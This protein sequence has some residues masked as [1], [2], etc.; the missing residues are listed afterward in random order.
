MT[1]L[2]RKISANQVKCKRGR[3]RLGQ[4]VA[5]SGKFTRRICPIRKEAI[6]WK[7]AEEKKGVT[8][9]DV[10]PFFLTW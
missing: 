9:I 7:V 5:R 1:G 3:K 6:E 2:L 10:T 4:G 8:S